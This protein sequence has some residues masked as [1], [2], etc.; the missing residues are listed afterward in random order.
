[1]PFLRPW[2]A[3]GSLGDVQDTG[4]AG[5]PELIPQ[6]GIGAH[7][8]LRGLHLEPEGDGVHLEPLGIKDGRG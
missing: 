8:Q 1:V 3:P 4:Q 7:R 2:P 6:H 5:A